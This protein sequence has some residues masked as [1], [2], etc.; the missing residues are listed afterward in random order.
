MYCVLVVAHAQQ[1]AIA[2]ARGVIGSKIIRFCVPL[3]VGQLFPEEEN[4]REAE[5]RS[6][7]DRAKICNSSA[8]QQTQHKSFLR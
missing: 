7:A 3:A 2:L 4:G 8:S 5:T 1:T 6:E